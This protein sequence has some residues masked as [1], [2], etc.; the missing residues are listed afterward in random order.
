M[1]QVAAGEIYPV[2]SFDHYFLNDDT[3][4]Y[5][6]NFFVR[7]TFDGTFDR[8]LFVQAVDLALERHPLLHSFLQGKSTRNRKLLAYVPGVADP[9]IRWAR[10]GEP[11]LHP[12]P[13]GARIDLTRDY[14][15]RL[16]IHEGPGESILVAQFHHAVVDGAGG[17]MFMEDILAFYEQLEKQKNGAAGEDPKLRPLDPAKLHGREDF[18]QTPEMLK[19]RRRMDLKGGFRLVSNFPNPMYSGTAKMKRGPVPAPASVWRE[20]DGDQFKAIRTACKKLGGTVNDYLIWSLFR[21]LDEWNR[22]HNNGKRPK[23]RIGIA[24]N[25]RKPPE[26]NEIPAFNVTSMYFINRQGGLLDDPEALFKSVVEET[27]RL[28][29]DYLGMIFLRLS[30]L[31]GAIPGGFAMMLKPKP[32]MPA[33]MVTA[34]LSNLGLALADSPLMH[35]DGKI[36]AGSLT[37]KRMELMPPFRYMTHGAF[38]V[39]S[40]GGRMALTFHYDPRFLNE[41]TADNFIQAFA[42]RLFQFADET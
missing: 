42:D 41:E 6:A 18:H 8:A 11:Y 35:A 21:T 3:N 36:R 14:G 27:T 33:C 10:M 17:R 38:G 12:S 16:F 29:N 20:F 7:M 1:N 39:A 28:K 34:N 32:L 24:I 26:D 30:R 5:P 40:Y 37:L 4:D 13:D 31:F 22:E 2:G 15:F 23:L 9:Y 25:M 19:A